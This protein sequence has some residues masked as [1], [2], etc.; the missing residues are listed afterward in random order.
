MVEKWTMCQVVIDNVSMGMPM[1]T[2]RIWR[3]MS[4]ILKIRANRKL[5]SWWRHQMETFPR[6]WPLVRDIHRSWMP[7]TKASDAEL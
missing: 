1:Q 5:L 6:Y 2:G 7:R 3:V 4:L